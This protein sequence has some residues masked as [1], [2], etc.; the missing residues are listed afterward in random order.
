VL[1]GG[2]GKDRIWGGAG[3]DKL[4]GGTGVDTFVFG[5]GELF[6]SKDSIT[7]FKF[8][9]DK[10]Q[11]LD[12]LDD[13]NLNNNLEDLLNA[14]VTASSGGGSLP[15]FTGDQLAVA[16]SGWTGPQSTS[17]QDL[18]VAMGANLAGHH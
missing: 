7:D 10:L 4:T 11:F 8:G 5:I 13:G 3:S 15:I 17:L 9:E 14:G 1:S 16:I 18:S 12:V 2:E 6:G